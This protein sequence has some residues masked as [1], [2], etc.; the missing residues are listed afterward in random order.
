LKEI[1]SKLPYF[2]ANRK[3]GHAKVYNGKAERG[4]IKQ[5]VIK[6]KTN[7]KVNC[8]STSWNPCIRMPQSKYSDTANRFSVQAVSCA[9]KQTS[10]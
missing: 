2:C 7:R 3:K 4:N 6:Y 8:S 5:L 9:M 10:F 1:L